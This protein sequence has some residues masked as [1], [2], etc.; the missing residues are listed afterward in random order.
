MNIRAK[1]RNQAARNA[2]R[3][4]FSLVEIMVVVVIIGLLAS[5][6]GV[7]VFNEMDKG[8]QNAARAQMRSLQ[9]ALD[10]YR[11]DCGSYPTTD[12]G[13]EVLVSATAGKTCRRYK[14]S[15]YLQ[16]RKVPADPWDNKYQYVRP[17]P[18][19]EPYIITSFGAD[20]QSGGDGAD[21]DIATN[22]VYSGDE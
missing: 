16:E 21:A 19:G 22:D 13:L 3:A 5:I 10:L 18:N 20:G 2:A 15:G 9:T 4:G 7:A 17:G 8:K 6:V 14:E 12:Q 11:L 1:I